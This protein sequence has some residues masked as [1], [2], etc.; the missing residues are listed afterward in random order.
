MLVEP[1]GWACYFTAIEIAVSIPCMIASGVGGQPGT[2]TSTGITF[3]TRP[4][5]A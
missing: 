3:E 5:L 1:P 2:A 4:R